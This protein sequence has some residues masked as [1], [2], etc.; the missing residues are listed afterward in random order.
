MADTG[1]QENPLDG[2]DKRLP[3]NCVEYLLFLVDQNSTDRRKELSKLEE[4]RKNAL[5]SAK[6]VAS[7][8]IWQRGEFSLEVKSDQGK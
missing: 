3:E 1:G 6:D 5:A 2:L 7:G 4:L 8:Y